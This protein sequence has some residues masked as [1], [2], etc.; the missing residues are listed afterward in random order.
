MEI[1]LS[2]NPPNSCQIEKICIFVT[3]HA[4]IST[5]YKKHKKEL[6]DFVSN[7][8]QSGQEYGDQDRNTLKLFRLGEEQIIIKSFKIPNLINKIA[9]RFIRKGKA[10][11]SFEYAFVLLEKGILTPQP[12]AYF[13]DKKGLFFG[14]SYYISHHLK[15]D[16]TYRELIHDSTFPNRYEILKQFTRFTFKLHENGIE[17]LDHSPGNTLIVINSKEDFDFYLVDLNRMKFHDY[18]DY[19]TRIK[20]FSRLT[21]DKNMVHAMSVEY[22]RLIEKDKQTVYNDM[23]EETEKFRIK[24]RKKKRL[25]KKIKFW[26]K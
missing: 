19:E 10:Q 26:E 3:M 23:W 18:M 25:K 9:Y 13:E 2:S 16:L 12:I 5:E 11:R 8:D 22:A 15:Y 1:I 6:T 24:F 4:E 17:F 14:K 7:F 20:N 21:P